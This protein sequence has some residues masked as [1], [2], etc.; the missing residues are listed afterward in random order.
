MAILAMEFL[1]LQVSIYQDICHIIFYISQ[2][3]IIPLSG[4]VVMNP[5]DMAVYSS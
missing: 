2:I 1:K 5:K 4:N 3:I